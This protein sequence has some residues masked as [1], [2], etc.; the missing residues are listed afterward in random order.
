MSI[1]AIPQWFKLQ[2]VAVSEVLEPCVTTHTH[3]PAHPHT[4]NNLRKRGGREN[5]VIVRQRSH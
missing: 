2:K 4:Y 1:E 5:E 3:T